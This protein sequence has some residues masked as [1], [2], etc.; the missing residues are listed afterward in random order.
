M[1][2]V[3]DEFDIWEPKQKS[4]HVVLASIRLGV[5]RRFRDDAKDWEATG[6]RERE[7]TLPEVFRRLPDTDI[8][9]THLY[10]F[11]ANP[12][13]ISGVDKAPPPL[14][15]AIISFVQGTY[16]PIFKSMTTRALAEMELYVDD[17]GASDPETLLSFRNHY[18]GIVDLLTYLPF[19]S[20]TVDSQAIVCHYH[21]W[22]AYIYGRIHR[23]DKSKSVEKERG[24]LKSAAREQLATLQKMEVPTR[25]P[26]ATLFHFQ[27]LTNEMDILAELASLGAVKPSIIKGRA[28]QTE[29]F[30]RV[31]WFNQLFPWRIE[32]PTQ[33]LIIAAH[34][35]NEPALLMQFGA[36]A[37]QALVGALHC[38][39]NK[40]TFNRSHPVINYRAPLFE[41]E[42][43]L[44]DQKILQ[45]YFE[46]THP[47]LI[48]EL[49][50]R[51][52]FKKPFSTRTAAIL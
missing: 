40:G 22:N 27:N 21:F 34:T 48:K 10:R 28:D 1:D 44:A 32:E 47:I 16:Q 4:P 3:D 24:N 46:K 20:R 13:G 33:A 36:L 23:G 41:D 45:D 17:K 11:P 7:L 42:K 2:D 14:T 50:L 29:Y 30:K 49:N 8:T 39:L 43:P 19:G 31:L 37:L 25:S 12:Y 38:A 35:G 5:L 26:L 52:I 6:F 15:N 18:G 9:D 51:E